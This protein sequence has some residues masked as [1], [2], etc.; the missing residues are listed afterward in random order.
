MT[1]TTKL[2][3]FPLPVVLFPGSILPLHIFE[4]RYKVMVGE[5]MENGRVF[6][7]LPAE[8]DAIRP[9]GCTAKIS[10]VLRRYPDG[11]ID[12]L[13]T[14]AERFRVSAYDNSQPYLQGQVTYFKDKTPD[15][16]LALQS[17]SSEV[18]KAYQKLADI[19]F[20]EGAANLDI[21]PEPHGSTAFFIASALCLPFDFRRQ[22]LESISE[23]ERL[24]MLKRVIDGALGEDEEQNPDFLCR[25]YAAN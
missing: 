10:S 16:P 20:P 11:R 7:V 22:L 13:T 24:C 14:G 3:L 17:L 4:P 15:S 18:I 23:E 6:G 12:I 8:G 19:V 2:A 5:C 25:W 1:N 21:K 9:V